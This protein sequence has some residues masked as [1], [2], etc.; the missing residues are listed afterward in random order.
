STLVEFNTTD[1]DGEMLA[2]QV[3]RSPV[4]ESN[5][6]EIALDQV[7]KLID[8]IIQANSV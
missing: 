6:R 2:S 8:E 5:A 3:R 4:Y 1:R 7:N